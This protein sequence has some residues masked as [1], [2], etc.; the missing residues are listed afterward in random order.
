MGLGKTGTLNWRSFSSLLLFKIYLVSTTVR[1]WSWYTQIT[2]FFFFEDVPAADG[3]LWKMP[4]EHIWNEPLKPN[5][6]KY[7]FRWKSYCWRVVDRTIF[8]YIFII[9]F[10]FLMWLL[11]DH[12]FT[13]QMR[14]NGSFQQH[15][16]GFPVSVITWAKAQFTCIILQLYE[17]NKL[18][19]LQIHL[20]PYLF[21][22]ML[23]SPHQK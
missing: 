8:I 18:F 9:I 6:K 23:A 17:S 22:L 12:W 4:T 19:K 16:S 21:R 1:R 3:F 2:L 10:F 14:N 13:K 20:T 5:R 15:F 7:H 11:T